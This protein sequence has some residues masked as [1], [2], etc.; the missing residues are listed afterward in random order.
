VTDYQIVRTARQEPG[1]AL[2]ALEAKVREQLAK[3]WVV[4]GGP[5]FVI[6]GHY[7]DERKM[8]FACQSLVKSD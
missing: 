1:E 6:S 8:F 2:D 7:L 3:G 4:S 5:S